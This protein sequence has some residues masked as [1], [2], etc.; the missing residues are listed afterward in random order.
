MYTGRVKGPGD[1]G[2]SPGPFPLGVTDV[3]D[4]VVTNEGER[5]LLDRAIRTPWTLSEVWSLHLYD[6]DFTP[7][8]E[9][10]IDDLTEA[11]FPGYA[12][13][14][15][16]REDWTLPVTVTGVATSWQGAIP[17]E[18]HATSGVT[19]IYGYYIMVPDEDVFLLAQRFDTPFLVTSSSPC[20]VLPQLTLHSESE[21]P[22]PPPPPPPP[23]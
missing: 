8:A 2:V 4:L 3:P 5:Y 7:C 18:F 15:L 22:C 21:P 6:N 10:E 11:S 14:D 23:P 19:T 9:M 13:I 1:T 16:P 20:R 17:K 12:A